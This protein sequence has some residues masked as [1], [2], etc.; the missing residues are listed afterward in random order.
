V[1]YVEVQ[2]ICGFGFTLPTDQPPNSTPQSPDLKQNQHL[3]DLKQNQHQQLSTQTTIRVSARYI[4]VVEK[5]CIFQRLNE[6]RLA[7]RL[8]MVLV[9]AKGMP[10]LATRAFLC[11]WVCNLGFRVWFLLVDADGGCIMVPLGCSAVQCSAVQCSAV[12]CSAV[13]CSAVQCSAVQSSAAASMRSKPA[14]MHTPHTT[15]A[16]TRLSVA[17]PHLPVLGLV[18]WNPAGVCILATYKFGNPRMGLE[19]SRWV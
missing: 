19:G 16:H 11:K 4:L 3:T 2:G 10:D 13:Q 1:G 6:D 18:D 8:P 12:Q 9:T 5:D 17:A 7:D 15:P 14:H